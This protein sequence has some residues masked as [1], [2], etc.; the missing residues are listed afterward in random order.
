MAL[1]DFLFLLLVFKAAPIAAQWHPI[2]AE[3]INKQEAYLFFYD[4]FFAAEKAEDI[5]ALK[6]SLFYQKLRE[7]RNN[8]PSYLL[9]VYLPQRKAYRYYCLG[10]QNDM[11]EIRVL[12][13]NYKQLLNDLIKVEA[14]HKYLKKRIAAPNIPFG[15]F[16]RD[17]FYFSA[18]NRMSVTKERDEAWRATLIERD[19]VMKP[20]LQFIAE[21][22]AQ[23]Y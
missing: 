12:E 9:E 1:K 19:S 16:Y 23:E 5:S 20:F 2:G 17:Q 21:D 4:Y 22:L 13:A 11:P 6:D 3:R 18:Q 15:Y 10:S 7:Y 14:T 8:R